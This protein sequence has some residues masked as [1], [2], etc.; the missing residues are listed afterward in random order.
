MSFAAN[1]HLLE[2][3]NGFSAK[4][5]SDLL[6]ALN[7]LSDFKGGGNNSS[8]LSGIYALLSN[9]S[10]N[11]SN[12]NPGEQ[13]IPGFNSDFFSGLF[14]LLN[15]L[16]RNPASESSNSPSLSL[17]PFGEGNS[18]LK[19]LF[20]KL[21]ELTGSPARENKE[22]Q[23]DSFVNAESEEK[24]FSPSDKEEKEKSPGINAFS[25]EFLAQAMAMLSSL[26]KPEKNETRSKEKK[27]K[28]E[29][30]FPPNAKDSAQETKAPPTER[31]YCHRDCPNSWCQHQRF[32]PSFAE[33][34]KMA[35]NWR[36]Y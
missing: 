24:G 14:S 35:E 4:G 22:K 3:L 23:N 25:P 29:D 26:N 18:E 34:K 2:F 31:L 27:R 10:K 36:R 6:S 12:K 13:K 21:Y 17:V 9:L 8:S 11:N 5:G 33:V 7:F 32:L 19:A 16:N 15:R 20:S 30:V 1:T 28:S